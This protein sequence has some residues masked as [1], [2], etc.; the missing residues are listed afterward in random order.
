M[1]TYLGRKKPRAK[2]IA[3]LGSEA[4][5]KETAGVNH[6]NANGGEA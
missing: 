4:M 3:L 6:A 1:T 5:K 2:C